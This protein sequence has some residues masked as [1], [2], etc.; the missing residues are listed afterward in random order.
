MPLARQCARPSSD[1]ASAISRSCACTAHQPLSG[2]SPPGGACC[3]QDGTGAALLDALSSR[4][5]P[6]GPRGQGLPPRGRGVADVPRPFPPAPS[7]SLPAPAPSPEALCLPG[8]PGAGRCCRPA[9]TGRSLLG[10]RPLEPPSA[11]SQ[12]GSGSC[13]L[14]KLSP[15]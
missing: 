2:N 1:S 7:I 15:D 6:R 5:F 11:L 14:Q 9:R 4:G 3:G 12:P 10:H 8:R 13:K